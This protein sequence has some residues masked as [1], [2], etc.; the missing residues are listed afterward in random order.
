MTRLM[1][2]IA[3]VVGGLFLALAYA[4][5]RAR[6]KESQEQG[7]SSQGYDVQI[8]RTFAGRLYRRAASLVALY[9]LLGMVVGAILAGAAWNLMGESS[10][11]IPMAAWM[12]CGAVGYM[13]GSERA[14]KLRF[15]AQVALCQ[16]QI[17]VNTK[18]TTKLLAQRGP[19]RSDEPKLATEVSS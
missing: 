9:S 10:V 16:A 15:E 7:N 8:I 17:E 12:F 14:F 11:W 18:A 4:R 2:L 6:S 1:A 3:V 19:V 13:I 5:K